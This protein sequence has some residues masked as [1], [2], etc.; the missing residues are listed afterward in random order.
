ML[1]TGP[2]TNVSTIGI[3]TRMHGKRFAW[4]F[5]VAMVGVAVALG[6]LVNLLLPS[7][8]STQPPIDQEAVGTPLQLLA[9][10]AVALLYA[11]AVLRRGIRG[12]LAELS[13]SE[14]H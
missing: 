4:L 7:L 6:L 5:S 2:A 10:A 3:L 9:V 13:L 8:P 12:F 14:G 1:L 11:A